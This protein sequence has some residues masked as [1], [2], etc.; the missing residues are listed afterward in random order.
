[1]VRRHPTISSCAVSPDGERIYVAYQAFQRLDTL[2]S[3]GTV[4]STM[5][6]P[7]WSESPFRIHVTDLGQV[8]V[9]VKESNIIIQVERE[10]R[11]RLAEVVTKDDG[12]NKPCSVFY[13]KYTGQMV[14][15]MWDNDEIMVFKTQFTQPPSCTLS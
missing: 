11:K 8:L 3:D 7:A 1:M 12:L 14:V 2:S 9:C 6:D 4:I 13:S 10:G 15:G 5:T